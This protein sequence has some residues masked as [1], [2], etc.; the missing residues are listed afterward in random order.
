VIMFFFLHLSCIGQVA[1][2]LRSVGTGN[3]NVANTWERYNGSI[4]ESSGIGANNPGQIPTPANN[5]FIQLTHVVTITG[6][7]GCNDLTITGSA[8]INLSSFIFSVGG[9]LTNYGSVGL[10]ESTSTV[11]FNGTSA[12]TITTSGGEDFF[13]L[14]KT[15]SGTLTLNSDVRFAGTSSELN[16]SAGVLDAGINTLS[17]TASTGLTMSGG[18][19]KLAQLSITLPDF[20]IAIGYTFTGGTIELNGAGNQILRGSRAYRGL[21]FSNSGTKTLTSTLT[22]ITGTITVANAAILDVGN[23][24]TGAGATNLT[25]TG[26]SRYIN[27]GSGAKPDAGGTYS[28]AIGT[29]IEFAGTSATTIR[30]APTYAN[31]VVSGANISNT[32]LVTGIKMQI[33][34]VFTVKTGAT[35]NLANTAGF[36]GSAATAVSNANTPSITLESNS[37]INYNGAAQTITNTQAYENLILGGSGIKT[38]PTTNLLINGDLTRSGTH[39]FDSNSGRVIFQGTT[40]QTYSAAVGTSTFDFYNISNTNTTNFIVNSPFGV[41]NELNLTSTAKLNLN[42]GDITLRSSVNRTSHIVDL[43]TTAASINISYGTGRFSIERYLFAIKS[44]RYLATPVITLANGDVTSPTINDSWREGG[45]AVT[46]TGNGYGTRITGPGAVG[47]PGGVDQNTQRGSMKSYNASNNTFTEI[48]SANL[49]ANKTIANDEG[50]AVFIN[51]D[52]GVDALSGPTVFGTTTLRMKGK[53]RTGDQ[54]FNA[55]VATGPN[56]GFQSVGNPFASQINY[57]TVTKSNL[58][59]SVTV[60]NPTAGFYGVGRYVQYVSTTGLNGDYINGGNTVNTIE[61]GQAFFIQSAVGVSGSITIKE[62]DKLSGSNLVSRVGVTSPTLEINLHARNTNTTETLLD[63]VIFNF[64]ASYN[65]AFDNN[66]VRKFMNS[67]DNLSIKNGNRNLIVERKNILTATDTI[68]LNLT[69]TRIA[70]YRFE[71]DPSVLSNTGLDAFLKDKFLQTETTISLYAVTNVDFDIT[72]DAGSKV[73]DRFMIVFKQA[74]NTSFTTISAIRNTDKTVTVQWG[75]A[76]ERNVA[77]YAIEQSNDGI[78]FTTIA[79]QTPTANNGNNTTYSKQDAT[80]SKANNWYR[81][82]ANNTN[83]TTKYTAIAM[84]GAVNEIIQIGESKISIY[85]NPVVN[86][87]VNLHFNNQPKGNYSIQITN[88]KGQQIKAV[89]ILVESNNSIRIVKIGMLATGAYQAT[90]TNETGTKTTIPFVLK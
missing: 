73:A 50:Y 48:T 86:G 62:S 77:N 75:T 40:A 89:N 67:T 7:E 84:I 74:Q 54:T 23:F 53:I 41:L 10:T 14:T 8:K 44:W 88:A 57:K 66:D 42:I 83:G 79:T 37:T 9:N 59:S 90:V 21:T 30:L 71:I 22:S 60:W 69:S 11:D 65:N 5:V 58:E 25:M 76:T 63:N 27:A 15:G 29:T 81:V 19:L 31:I 43:G 16:I 52:R 72:A 36:T 20:P 12:Q 18:T 70:P 68:F 85:P 49:A 56:D 32:S 6:N 28:L 64:D 47:N 78:N 34:S 55:L 51:G 45:A 26:T 39:T 33:G 4:W 80:A 82:K 13:K 87:N 38:A 17:G 61:S 46:G 3:W 1:G 35:F 24:N 2:D